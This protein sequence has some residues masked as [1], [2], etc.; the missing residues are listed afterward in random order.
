MK[1]TP[2]ER[3]VQSARRKPQLW[4]LV[5]GV[6][7]I[8]ACAFLWI[9][10]LLGVAWLIGDVD[11]ALIF[12]T[13]LSRPVTPRAVLILLSTFIGMALGP[14]L[15]VW[16]IHGRSAASLFGP[17]VRVLRDFAAAAGIVLAIY[18]I[19]IALWLTMYQPELNLAPSRWLLL[20]PLALI[21]V[22]IQ[23]G[24]EEMIFR[25]YLMQQLGAR[26]ASPLVWLLLP[27]L[28]FGA[29]H[30]DPG[31]AGVNVWLVVVSATLFGLAAGDLTAKT[32]SLGAAW[33]FHFANNVI[34]I[35][36]LATK[37]TITGMAL[38]VTP[39][40]VDDAG[41]LRLLMFGDMGMLLVAWVL[42]RRALRP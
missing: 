25:G 3:Y 34:A 7:L 4:R 13:E 40:A 14:V 32:G 38:F 12:A 2:F 39:Y 9:G 19:G 41:P 23:T 33:G 28:A 42:V 24:A 31:T 29:V 37:G 26:F 16:L 18:G 22:A 36:I 15:A 6:V 17:R 35:L 20:L 11:R 27:A 10:G 30:Y 5:P 1:K 21:G 8:V